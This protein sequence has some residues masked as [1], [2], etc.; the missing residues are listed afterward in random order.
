MWWKH[1]SFEQERKRKN[2]K[3]RPKWEAEREW[4]KWFAWYPVEVE[5]TKS[6]WLGFVERKLRGLD[7]ER[8][9]N[10]FVWDFRDYKYRT[11]NGEKA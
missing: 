3:L 7:F 4:H 9:P 8:Q 2:A 10:W 5:P 1:E 11:K 6:V